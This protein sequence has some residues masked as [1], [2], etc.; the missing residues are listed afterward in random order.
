[1]QKVNYIHLNPVRGKWKFC[2][3]WEDYEHRSG[4]FY[5]KNNEDGFCPEHF[6]ELD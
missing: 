2:E 5:V 3:H 1:M 4:K 6:E